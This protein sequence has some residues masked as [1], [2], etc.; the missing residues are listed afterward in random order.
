MKTHE[1]YSI[2]ARNEFSSNSA[3]ESLL[4][5]TRNVLNVCRP[6]HDSHAKVGP[7]HVFVSGSVI[8]KKPRIRHVKQTPESGA[9][10]V[11]IRKCRD[12]NSRL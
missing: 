6:A 10:D 7:T 8:H 9:I 3:D 1:Q 2:D 5:D 4:F 12:C 11:C